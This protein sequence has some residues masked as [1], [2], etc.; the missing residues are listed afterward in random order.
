MRKSDPNFIFFPSSILYIPTAQ[1]H[2]FGTLL[3]NY[4]LM[5]EKAQTI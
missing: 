1:K 2:D 4:F 5:R 3:N